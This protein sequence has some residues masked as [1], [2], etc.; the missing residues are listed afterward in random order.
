M[1]FPFLEP[2]EIAGRANSLCREAFGELPDGPVDLDAL[3][4]DHLYEHHGVAFFK[5]RPLDPQDGQRV[6][7][8]T[9]PL[10]NEIHVDSRLAQS[11][12]VGRYRFTV[13]HEI[14]HWVLH[15]PLFLDAHDVDDDAHI[16]TL[17][18]DV[19]EADQDSYHPEEW[20]ANHFA[21]SLLLNDDALRTHFHERFGEPPLEYDP[22]SEHDSPRDYS[23]HVA[24]AE[25]GDYPCLCEVFRLS[26][27]ATAIA[28]EERGYVDLP[29]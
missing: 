18:R 24:T 8:M 23:R 3:L 19:V 15:R 4:F 17:E 28:L 2:E 5:D 9:Y 14:G 27:E 1:E 20:Q 11:D 12:Q 29:E 7:G 13:A 10:A 6:L 26:A 22:G 25:P 21:I 16:V